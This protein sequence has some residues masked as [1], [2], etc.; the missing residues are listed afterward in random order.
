LQIPTYI[1]TLAL[2][3]NYML[4]PIYDSVVT[5]LSGISDI[6]FTINYHAS[7]IHVNS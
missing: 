2:L 7:I 4:Y 1:I 5:R 3:D 6:N